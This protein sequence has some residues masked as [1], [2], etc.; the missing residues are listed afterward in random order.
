[1]MNIINSSI[2]DICIKGNIYTGQKCPVCHGKM[3]FNERG[4]NCFCKKC[5][6]PAAGGYYVR[7]GRDICK[8]FQNNIDAAMQFLTGLRFKTDEKTYNKRDYQ[9]DFP[10]GFATQAEKWLNIKKSTVKPKSWNNLNNYMA[11]AI[12]A[13][14]QA[15]VKIINFAMIEDFL[16]D[17]ATTGNDKTRSNIKS[18]LNDFFTWLKKRENIPVPE[19]PDCNFELGWRKYTDLETQSLILDQIK[20]LTYHVNKKIWFGVELLASYPELR[21]DD[22]RRIAEADFNPEFSTITIHTPTKKK[23]KFKVI[24]LIPEHAVT[25][26]SLKNER[27][28][29]PN[30]PFF[31]HV[32]GIKGCKAESIFGEKYLYKWWIKAC[33]ALNI[34]GL[35]LYGGTRHTTTTELARIAGRDN[36]KK[37]TGHD[38][39]RAFERYCQA[40]DNTAFEMAKIIAEKKKGG[41]VHEF[42]KVEKSP[43]EIK[44]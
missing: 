23:N 10:L 30:M 4:R 11:K 14:H 3:I 35:D 38:T 21:P 15:N 1:M 13:W 16:F 40:Q 37:A 42:K 9:K 28:G 27:S 36:A 31:R 24:K 20:R 12:K 26:K 25:W 6:V 5:N 43:E 44:E 19:M 7:F 29:L 2:E 33:E 17:P 18:C 39:N 34:S 41:N 32:D 22:L 8:R